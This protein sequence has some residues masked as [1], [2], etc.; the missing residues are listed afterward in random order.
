MRLHRTTLA[1]TV[2]GTILLAACGGGAS[3]SGTRRPETTK[4]E[5]SGSGR[6]NHDDQS[7]Q[8][9]TQAQ[10]D[11][12]AA[13]D[14]DNLRAIPP[15]IVSG[16]YLT[17][18][19]IETIHYGCSAF[20][21]QDQRLDLASFKAS[22]HLATKAGAPVDAPKVELPNRSENVIWQVSAE[23]I[24]QGLTASADVETTD[25]QT[26]TIKRRGTT[27]VNDMTLRG[28]RP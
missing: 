17:C 28:E 7:K 19:P 1:S 12:E 2:I 18:A 27:T 22:F 11:G 23:L 6:Q 26:L 8:N 15:E 14:E 20:D 16:A 5:S 24:A 3:L 10:A 13:S 4:E 21:G 25:G 9:D